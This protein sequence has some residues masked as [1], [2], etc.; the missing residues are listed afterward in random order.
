MVEIIERKRKVR[1]HPLQQRNDRRVDRP[2]FAPRDEQYAD[3]AAV[4][5][6]RQPRRR[7]DMSSG[8]TLTPG[9]RM[10]VVEV[11]V[12]D[13]EF[14]IAIG[15]SAN[16]GAFGRVG[17]DRYVEATQPCGVFAET[18]RKPKQIGVRLQQEDSRRQEVPAGKR[19][20]ADLLV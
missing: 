7:T 18:R 3:A 5:G 12:A 4:A 15:P 9:Q 2:G 1:R 8:R 20:F 19:G 13:A 11:I 16:P 10:R 6:Q 17:H 14:P